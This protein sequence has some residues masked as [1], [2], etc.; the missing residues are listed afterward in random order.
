MRPDLDERIPRLA[1]HFHRPEIR[2]DLTEAL[3]FPNLWEY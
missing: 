3:L 2:F 1:V